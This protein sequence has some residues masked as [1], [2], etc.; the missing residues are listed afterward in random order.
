[1]VDGVVRR[2]LGLVESGRP[3]RLAFEPPKHVSN[4]LSQA[5]FVTVKDL[6]VPV[7]ATM[8]YSLHRLVG[9]RSSR[10]NAMLDTFDRSF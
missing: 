1:L 3:S 7:D 9:A 6:P 5:R 4:V 8:D 10:L 2:W